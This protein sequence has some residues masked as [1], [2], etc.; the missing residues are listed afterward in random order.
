[1]K[2]WDIVSHDIRFLVCHKL[3]SFTSLLPHLRCP[4]D[5]TYQFE[6]PPSEPMVI[7][8]SSHMLVLALFLQ[9][10]RD[11]SCKTFSVGESLTIVTAVIAI[12]TNV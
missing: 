4:R 5:V 9:C 10:N 7:A 12:S 11:E 6:V 8:K 3:S 1:M 2:I